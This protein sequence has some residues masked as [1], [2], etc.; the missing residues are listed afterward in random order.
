[1][2][3]FSTLSAATSRLLNRLEHI[4]EVVVNIS[5]DLGRNV[6]RRVLVVEVGRYLL[7]IKHLIIVVCVLGRRIFAGILGELDP[8]RPLVF[9]TLIILG[10]LILDVDLALLLP[11]LLGIHRV[12]AEALSCAL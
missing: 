11:L 4:V 12:L 1:L 3:A 5:N 2:C 8:R 10:L 9:L 7:G 6:D